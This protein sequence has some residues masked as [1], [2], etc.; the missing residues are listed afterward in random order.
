MILR[1]Y[2]PE[3]APFLADILHEAV[4]TI[5][6]RDYTTAQLDAWSPAPMLPEQYHAR[7]TDGRVVTVAVSNKDFPAA[8]IEFEGDGHI[9]CF[10]CHPDIAGS[11]VGRALFRHAQS[12]AIAAGF[13]RL[14]A[15]HKFAVNK[16]FA[17]I[18]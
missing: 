2:T 9:D 8:F 1:P 18:I 14:Y 11:G 5:G 3:D 4:H 10:Y 17:A 12:Q 6:A 13:T 7:V 15:E 16:A